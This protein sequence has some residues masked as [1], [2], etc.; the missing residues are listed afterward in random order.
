MTSPA[1][2]VQ[3]R[4][5]RQ[6]VAVAV[7][8]T[9]VL[10]LVFAAMVP[11]AGFAA[12]SARLDGGLV[13]LRPLAQRSV[14]YASDGTTVLGSLGVEDRAV[15]TL[16][17]VPKR[18]VDAI[19]AI[20][21]ATFFTNPGV[22]V[23]AITRALVRNL[24]SGSVLQGG[25]TITQQLVKNRVLTARRDLE[26]KLSEFS[27]AVQL[28]NRYS[29]RRILTEY[30][31]TV[32]F[33][34]G[35]YGLRS[36]AERFFATTDP[37]T[38]AARPKRLDELTLGEQALLA[39]SIASPEGYNPFA[40]PELAR[41]RRTE[42]LDR[43]VTE[44]MITRDEAGVAA[45]EP[46]PTIRPPVP[47]LRPR[48]YFVAEVQRA[49]LDDDRL[50]PTPKARRETLLRGGL[51]ITTTLD[52]A[53][54]RD[55]EAAVAEQ[56][57]DQAPFTA[58][59][60]A[61]DPATGAVRALIGGPG[62]DR[63]QYDL[64]THEPGRQAGSTYKMITLAAALELGYSPDDRIDGTSPCTATRPPLPPWQTQN[65]EP[66]GGI[67]TLRDAS[68]LSVNCAFAH[69]IAAVG[70]DAVV[71]MAHR[72]GVHQ[73][74]PKF[75]SITLG[76]IDT[77]PL[78]MATVAATLAAGGV[79]HDPYFVE[80]VTA[81]GGHVLVDQ[82]TAGK[83]VLAADVAACTVDVLRGG[84]RDGT[85][86]AAA[87]PGTDIAGKTGTTDD[88]ADAWFV[89]MT[90][91]LAT[92]V[93]M[94]APEG[95]IPMRSVGGITVFGGTYPARI[96]HDFTERLVGRSVPS[97]LPA[98]GPVCSRPGTFVTDAGRSVATAVPTDP[99]ATSTPAAT[100]TTSPSAPSTTTASTTTTTAPATT[101]P[102]TTTP[103]TTTAPPTTTVPNTTAPPAV[104][105]GSTSG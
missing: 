10:S 31:N 2:T 79:R 60:V 15:V 55:A 44:R 73:P 21:D 98:A 41:Q 23:A 30:L 97:V 61:V 29:K 95:K 34:E 4:S 11:L 75:L 17:E 13:P 100:T 65:N 26:R 85:G 68:R 92:A 103:P 56:L 99:T 14:V 63:F 47:D 62:F 33:G 9:V 70:P 81:P 38:G 19:L 43:M 39:G 46:L 94:G 71:D 20:E 37:A 91:N 52:P 5:S 104:G 67:L 40:F 93:W 59:V 25:S 64:A 77:T 18:Q 78:E 16:D 7:A 49:L 24:G 74:V 58:A 96:F 35:A 101:R 8:G 88:K 53:A 22:D 57:P 86:T 51:S 69:L 45:N 42:V 28:T 32:Y 66:G 105:G 3:Q 12:R 50:G 80:K 84:V 87:V 82:D 6:L 27:L 54:Q 76:T 89:G 83:R 48:D 102:A 72:L 1:P 90:S 36:A